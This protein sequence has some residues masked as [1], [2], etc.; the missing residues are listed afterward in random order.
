MEWNPTSLYDFTRAI[1]T[2]LKPLDHEILKTYDEEQ[3]QTILQKQYENYKKLFDFFKTEYGVITIK[4]GTLVFHSNIYFQE[5]LEEFEPCGTQMKIQD[6]RMYANKH[7]DLQPKLPLS[8][9]LSRVYCNFTPAGNMKVTGNMNIG[10][11]MYVATK[12]TYFFQIPYDHHYQHLK[13]KFQLTS[14]AFFKKYIKENNTD[15]RIYSG[16]ILST[17]V[18]K[19]DVID[20]GATHIP[21]G[22][23]KVVY[24]EILILDGFD[25]FRKIGQYDLINEITSDMHTGKGYRRGANTYEYLKQIVQ[26][27]SYEGRPLVPISKQF[28]NINN[29]YTINGVSIIN[30]I[31]VHEDFIKRSSSGYGNS[32]RLLGYSIDIDNMEKRYFKH[33]VFPAIGSTNYTMANQNNL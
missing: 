11:A 19:T 9:T 10:E 13:D 27:K 20:A 15:E 16:F 18:D 17:T 28:S 12:D 4:R 3:Q 29:F 6:I 1:D 14:T 31:T 8:E 5:H 24:P 21:L 25:K 32:V 7:N 26:D 22:Y 33:S 23:G 30:T 2:Y